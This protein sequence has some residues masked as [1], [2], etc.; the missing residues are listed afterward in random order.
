MARKEKGTK[1]LNINSM[2]D[3]I[4]SEDKSLEGSFLHSHQFASSSYPELNQFISHP[5]TR[6]L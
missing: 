6:F 5:S 1:K 2:E 4:S 3:K